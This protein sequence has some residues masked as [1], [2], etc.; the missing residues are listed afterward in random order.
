MSEL[1]SNTALLLVTLL[2]VSGISPLLLAVGAESDDLNEPLPY[3][4]GGV[5]I[6]D[7]ADFEIE[8]G[9]EYLMIEEEQPV[10][11]AFS[12]LKQEW[13]DAGRPGVEDMVYEPQTSARA[14]G[15]ACNS[16]VVNDQ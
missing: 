1:R 7:I 3:N 14:G 4:A 10:V 13:I 8:M 9:N 5:V 15:R 6:G 11:S 16:H 12:F 2:F